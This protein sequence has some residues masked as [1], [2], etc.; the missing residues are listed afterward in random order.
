MYDIPGRVGSYTLLA[1]QHEFLH[2]NPGRDA[3]CLVD[4]LANFSQSFGAHPNHSEVLTMAPQ[5]IILGTWSEKIG[6][7]IQDPLSKENRLAY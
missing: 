5:D 3:V 1:A 4:G 7:T 6:S 2:H